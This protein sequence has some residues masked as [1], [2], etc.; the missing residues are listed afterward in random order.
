VTINPGYSDVT[1]QPVPTDGYTT[2]PEQSLV[3]QNG[4]F[5]NLGLS[6]IL[7][8]NNKTVR[9]DPNDTRG[10]VSWNIGNQFVKIKVF[11]FY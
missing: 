4:Q 7:S 2:I 5:W 6:K 1:M 10:A 11:N 8:I 9:A 3:V